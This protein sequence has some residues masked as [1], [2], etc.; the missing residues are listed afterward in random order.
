MLNLDALILLKN[1][2]TNY[3][4][5]CHSLLHIVLPFCSTFFG[6]YGDIFRQVNPNNM[7]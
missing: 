1:E 4:S 5:Y 3:E 7:K 2:T 6:Y